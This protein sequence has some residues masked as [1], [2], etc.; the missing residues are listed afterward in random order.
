[1]SQREALSGSKRIVVKVGTSSITYPNGRINL[2]MLERLSWVLSDIRNQGKDVI[3]VSS[4]SI[5][6]GSTRL[7]FAERPKEIRRKQ[8]AA[9]VGQAV[10]VQIYQNFFNEYSQQVAQILLTKEDFQEG[11]RRNNTINTFE[12]LLEL[13]VIPI[14]NAN[15]T[16]STFEIEFSDNDRLSA[17]VAAATHADLLIL[18]TDIDSLYNSDP[19]VNPDAVRIKT[20]ESITEEILQMG[21]EEGSA[22][23]VGGMATKILA[24]QICENCNINMVVAEGS[25]PTVLHKILEGED[26]G[27]FFALKK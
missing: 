4:G 6:V 16:I 8:A 15:D 22:F 23:S 18:L 21:G 3:L 5:G 27:T 9:A 17:N 2:K 7:G 14:V 19:K 24:A 20:V 25:D 13:G 1:M 12:T 26:I 10:L 11:E